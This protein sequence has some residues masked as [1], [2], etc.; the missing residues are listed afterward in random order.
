MEVFIFG[1]LSYTLYAKVG[2]LKIS[3]Y[4]KK[5][6]SLILVGQRWIKM[7]RHAGKVQ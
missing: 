7:L 1:A 4:L 6:P 2:A 3:I 5:I